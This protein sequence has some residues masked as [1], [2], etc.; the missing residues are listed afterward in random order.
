MRYAA[1]VTKEGRATLAEFPDC[2]GCQTFAEVGEDIQVQAADVL[3]GWLEATLVA[4][5]APQPRRAYVSL[6]GR[7]DALVAVP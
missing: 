5:E 2:P 4:G 7:A 1:I 6:G 3:H